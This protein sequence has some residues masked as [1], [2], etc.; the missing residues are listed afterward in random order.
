[1]IKKIYFILVLVLG[2]FG[3]KSNVYADAIKSCTLFNEQDNSLVYSI[4]ELKQGTRG[5]DLEMSGWAFIHN[6][7]QC[8][9]G[10]CYG[11]SNYYP[12]AAGNYDYTNN[13]KTLSLYGG[14][15]GYFVKVDGKVAS[16]RIV[17]SYVNES[18]GK[19]YS[20]YC[21][22]ND[23]CEQ[24]IDL[25]YNKVNLFSW[26]C[27][28]SFNCTGYV[29][30]NVGFTA[31]IKFPNNISNGNYKFTIS[32]Q[33][34][35]VSG[36][37]KEVDLGVSKNVYN[38]ENEIN[39]ANGGKLKLNNLTSTVKNINNYCKGIQARLNNEGRF[40]FPSGASCWTSGAEYNILE[41]FHYGESD[42]SF[43]SKHT[44]PVTMYRM[45]YGDNQYWAPAT[46]FS[47]QAKP[48][49]ITINKKSDKYCDAD[50]INKSNFSSNNCESGFSYSCGVMTVTNNSNKANVSVSESAMWEQGVYDSDGKFNSTEKP[51]NKIIVAGKGFDYGL[52]YT[53]VVE[54][55]LNSEGKNYNNKKYDKNILDEAVKNRTPLNYSS[56]KLKEAYS[57][58]E[59]NDSSL[60]Y[61]GSWS[62]E[63]TKKTYSDTSVTLS[64]SCYYKLKYAGI[65]Y[66]QNNHRVDY[67]DNESAVNTNKYYKA[68]YYYYIPLNYSNEYFRWKLNFSDLGTYSF[69][70]GVDSTGKFIKNK[71]LWNVDTSSNNNSAC[72]VNVVKTN[73][74]NGGDVCTGLDCGDYYTSDGLYIPVYRSIS[75]SDPFPNYSVYPNNWEEYDKTHKYTRL[76]NTY[77]YG[78]HYETIPNIKYNNFGSNYTSMDDVKI[79]GTAD[80]VLNSGSGGYFSV[81]NRRHCKWGEFAST[82]DIP[83]E[84]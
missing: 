4:E 66:Y 60:E 31:R 24:V 59:Y 20:S 35:D 7:H 25:E 8:G 79:D 6:C 61:A 27:N 47:T 80:I 28:G 63:D 58:W 30:D 19:M 45:E 43:S 21:S 39:L 5:Y 33:L 76:V 36:T 22:N 82:C 9:D 74:N 34:N 77:D 52:K 54:I 37:K 62:C 3:V 84:S 29:T 56:F 53:S 44:R 42:Y 26:M 68:G 65:S 12:N 69:I 40:T 67:F 71:L 81:I 38:G 41:E 73:N 72:Y 16:S 11:D 18:T 48:F 75:L 15:T 46:W 51:F 14:G 55:K 64:Q 10:K 17:I 78:V 50:I 13:Q 49:K 83:I 57:S 1:M 32:V 70:T 2:C 23:N